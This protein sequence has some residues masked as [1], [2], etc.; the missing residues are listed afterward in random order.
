MN[1][2]MLLISIM[3]IILFI[4]LSGCDELEEL[5]KPDYINVIVYCDVNVVLFP[6][7]ESMD[8]P[9]LR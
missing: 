7:M 9:T 8:D 3:S 2:K 5:K 6:K 1:T 4:G